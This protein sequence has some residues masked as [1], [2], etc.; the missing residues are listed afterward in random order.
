[1]HL[2]FLNVL[3]ALNIANEKQYLTKRHFPKI[4]DSLGK[5]LDQTTKILICN[6]TLQV[7]LDDL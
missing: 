4:Q 6:E 5:I 1:M 3:N 7:K 2:S